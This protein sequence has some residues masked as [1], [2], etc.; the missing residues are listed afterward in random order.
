MS[1]TDANP[2]EGR[3]YGL[4]LNH[5]IYLFRSGELQPAV[6]NETIDFLNGRNGRKSLE[7]ELVYDRLRGDADVLQQRGEVSSDDYQSMLKF[8]DRMHSY[9]G[10]NPVEERA[11][12][13]V[14]LRRLRRD[15][16]PRRVLR[17][18]ENLQENGI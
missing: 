11:R 13:E 4:L 1:T 14:N 3:V 18:A 6:Y 8:L 5:V 17:A 15:G 7:R 12:A 10:I 16:A 2:E 9:S